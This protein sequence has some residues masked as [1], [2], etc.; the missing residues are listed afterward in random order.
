MKY[1]QDDS[2][3]HT[4]R[5]RAF[6]HAAEFGAEASG[7]EADTVRAAAY[8]QIDEGRR[9]RQWVQRSGVDVD[10][11]PLWGTFIKAC[12]TPDA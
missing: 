4:A 3:C 7:Q 9:S 6:K 2:A 11:R 8:P 10:H 12:V 5:N 1:S